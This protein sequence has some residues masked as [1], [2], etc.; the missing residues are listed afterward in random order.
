MFLEKERW[1]AALNKALDK[2]IDKAIIN[3]LTEPSFRDLMCA[4]IERGEYEI[5]PPHTAK[6][7][8]DERDEFGNMK[9]RI[10]HAN[11]PID[12]VFCS[13]L[14]DLLFDM[15]GSWVHPNCRSYIKGTGCGH[16]VRDI[17]KIVVNGKGIVGFKADLSKYFDSVPL[18]Y[19]DAAF[20][21]VESIVGHSAVIDV[22][23]KYYHSD[24]FYDSEDKCFKEEFKSLKQG[25]AV[26]SWLADVILYD[27]DEELSKLNVRYVRY[28]DDINVMGPDYE[29]AMQILQQRLAE[30]EI[31][32]NPKKVEY[33]DKDHW[34][35]F[36]GFALK[37]DLI[38]LPES[39][40]KKFQKE[41]EKRTIKAARP[42]GKRKRSAR[43]IVA[44]VN[45]YL[46]RGYNGHSWASQVLPVINS[47]PDIQELNKFVLDAIRA[48]ITGK[49]KIG[50]LGFVK[51][52]KGACIARG[53]GQNVKANR[54]KTGDDI[55]G[56]LSIGCAHKAM[57]T[58][59]SSYEALVRTA[60]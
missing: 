52:K 19:I 10:V 21:R 60:L 46:Y 45:R 47:E 11:E 51:N 32:L 12:R 15:F 14:N 23:R 37:G 56:Y 42:K 38:S 33:I 2:G 24:L 16:V 6:I 20:D 28:C 57:I 36:L 8:K 55:Y 31:R 17:S 27:I 5:A 41:I 59:R 39:R 30:K 1:E 4:A 13:L 40:I 3:R 54:E 43:T 7:P 49:T 9:Y 18:R 22:I 48:A 35:K 26:A 44:S 25:C 34:F 50:G 29:L 58:S 53:K